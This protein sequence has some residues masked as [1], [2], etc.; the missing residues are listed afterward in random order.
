M[1]LNGGN[2]TMWLFEKR[3]RKLDDTDPNEVLLNIADKIKLGSMP[4]DTIAQFIKQDASY[5]EKIR[6]VYI[7]ALEWEVDKLKSLVIL[8]PCSMAE[9]HH[10]ST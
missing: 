1:L 9:H 4:H 6:Q 7:D 5:A 10:D 3:K 2:T 8:A